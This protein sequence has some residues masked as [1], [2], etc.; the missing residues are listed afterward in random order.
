MKKNIVNSIAQ[1]MA[2][3]HGSVNDMSTI[4]F[5]N[6]KRYNYTTPKTFLEVIALYTKILNEKHV[7]LTERIATLENG[8][9]KLADC[10][11]QVDG[12]QVRH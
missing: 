2:Y 8:L 4:Y 3:V 9:L 1:Y 6:E 5:Q 12:L 11:Q 10:S 7:Q